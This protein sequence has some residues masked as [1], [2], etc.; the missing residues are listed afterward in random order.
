MKD[1]F[2]DFVKLATQLIFNNDYYGSKLK[3]NMHNRAMKKLLLL[4]KEII[5]LND[6]D[7]LDKLLQ[8]EDERVKMHACDLCV[9]MDYNVEN[10]LQILQDLS[11]IST[12]APMLLGKCMRRVQ[13]NGTC[14]Y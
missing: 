3:V 13:S 6:I 4:K 7:L 2:N 12:E 9:T 8:H 1:Y 14:D 5:D 10:A 11:I